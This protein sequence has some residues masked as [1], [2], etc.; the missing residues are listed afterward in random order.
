VSGLPQPT[1]ALLRGCLLS[2]VLLTR[3]ASSQEDN[4]VFHSRVNVVQAPVVVRDAQGRAVGNLTQNDFQLFDKGKRQTITSFLVVKR[5]AETQSF[6]P[7]EARAAGATGSAEAAVQNSHSERHIVYV[8]DDLNNAFS[9]LAALREAALGHFKTGLLVTDR[10]AIYTFSGRSTLPFTGDPMKLDE[11]VTKLRLRP[12]VRHAITPCPD[13]SYYLANLILNVGDTRALDA[14]IKQTVEC[15]HNPLAARQMAEAAAKQELSNGEQDIYTAFR[16]IK[17]AIRLLAGMPGQRL[18]VLASP[19]IFAQTP[20]GIRNMTETLDL[21]ARNKVVISTLDA[22]GIVTLGRMDA[23]LIKERSKG[24]VEYYGLSAQVNSDFLA[25]LADGTGGTFFH[26]NNDLKAGLGRLTDVP[27]FSYVLGFTPTSLKTDGSFHALKIRLP[28]AKQFS[29]QARRGYYAL[30]PVSAEDA[31]TAEMRD[32][33]FSREERK[34]LPS[35]FKLQISRTNTGDSKLTVVTK[36]DPKGLHFEKINGRNC[37][38]LTIVSALFDTDG[39][40]LAGTTKTIN[41]KLR[42][43]TLAQMS[44]GISVPSDFDVKHEFI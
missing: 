11:T 6:Q 26:N 43:E 23:S 38:S 21:A 16:T 42:D 29:V 41:L 33:V 37:D 20:N 31:A 18:I 12:S 25:E 22:R 2:V 35:G 3:S 9:D 40:Y 19:G 36:V 10:V 39:G 15:S 24:E 14:V 30:A 7:P 17:N 1:V 32:A 8:F 28:N 4:S 44:A 34:G 27:E 13:V 5:S